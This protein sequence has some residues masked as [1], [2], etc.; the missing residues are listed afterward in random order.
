VPAAASPIRIAD[1]PLPE[2]SPLVRPAAQE[3]RSTFASVFGNLFG[4]AKQ[5]APAEGNRGAVALRGT[6][7]R[8]AATPKAERTRTASVSS[9]AAPVRHVRPKAVARAM[10]PVR[11]TAQS[12]TRRGTAAPASLTSLRTAFSGSGAD[13]RGMLAGAQPALPAGNFDARWSALH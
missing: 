3:K 6:E 1:V 12:P 7:A 8:L 2:P 5:R 9:H 13:A 11:Q 4:G 10:P